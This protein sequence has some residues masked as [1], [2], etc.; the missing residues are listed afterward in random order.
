MLQYVVTLTIL[1][2]TPQLS[3]GWDQ[4]MGSLVVTVKE[5]LA[6]PQLVLDQWFPLDGASADSQILLRAELKVMTHKTQDVMDVLE[7]SIFRDRTLMVSVWFQQI[8]SSKMVDMIGAG[9]LPCAG[10]GNG[11]VK[12]S[13]SYASKERK[14][15]VIVHA[16]RCVFILLGLRIRL[17]FVW[18]H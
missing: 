4:P 12:L 11:Q 16:C 15:G 7:P 9:T 17:S 18:F 13:L 8:L 10:S 6:Q 5:L 14:L 2:V 1:S 3:S